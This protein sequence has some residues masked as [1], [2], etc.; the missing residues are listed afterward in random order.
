MGSGDVVCE[1]GGVRPYP[2]DQRRVAA[3]QEWQAERIEARRDHAFAMGETALAVEDRRMKP[4]VVG[5]E[6]RR[7]DHG[8]ELPPGQILGQPRRVLPFC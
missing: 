8:P 2:V 5:P 6:A 4:A 3:A 7:P 1:M